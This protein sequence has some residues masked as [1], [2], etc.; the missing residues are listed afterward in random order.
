MTKA[1][2]ITLTLL[3]TACGQAPLPP[4]QPPPPPDPEPATVTV[5]ATVLSLAGGMATPN[6]FALRLVQGV[7]TQAIPI[8]SGFPVQVPAGEYRV[9]FT[10]VPGYAFAGYVGCSAD[11]V[12]ITRPGQSH[13][14]GLTFV[15]PPRLPEPP[16]IPPETSSLAVVVLGLEP[17]T[18][19][20]DGVNVTV[21]RN[22][23]EYRPPGNYTVT[24]KDQSGY[25][26]DKY[27]QTVVVPVGG[28]GVA[29]VVFTK[30]VSS[31][32]VGVMTGC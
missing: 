25:R 1:K 8:S 2:F 7:S 22:H 26:P 31:C 13:F 12:L 21:N 5:T 30:K 23:I 29:V 27:S 6:D 18:I 14:C 4:V 3:L 28:T 9:A 15:E 10:P 16:V 11:G 17:A 24:A 20:I 19:A 32:S